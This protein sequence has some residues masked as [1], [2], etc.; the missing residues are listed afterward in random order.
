MTMKNKLAAYRPLLWL[1]A[2]PVLNVFYALLNHGEN[3]AGNLV[4]DLDN[5]IPF[6]AAFAV[7]YLL[8]YP[9]VFLMLV[10]I[11][12]KNRKAYYQT[13]ITLC[14][15]LIV[16]Y[17]IYA[18][19]QTT[20]PRA[21]VTGDGAFDSL[22]H[23]IYATDQPY[24]CFPSI[25]V[26]TSYLIIKGVSASGN[27]GMFTRIAAGVF[28]WTIIASTLLIKQH[29]ILDAAGSIFLVELLFPVFG[30]LTGVFARRRS[31]AA[32]GLPGKAAM[33]SSAS[34]KISA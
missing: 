20:V 29:V 10:A 32:S 23:F 21:L 33:K 25:H 3:G 17:A 5:I 27:F 1:L 34:T 4:T 16:S 15:G 11:F 19:F 26:L 8:W 14:A 6:E 18:V 28:S 30:L 12:L 31:E 7:P 13:L 22:V 2:I 9:F 24:N